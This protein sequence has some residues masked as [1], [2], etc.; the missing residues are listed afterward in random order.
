[1][2]QTTKSIR[3]TPER[4]EKLDAIDIPFS[5]LVDWALDNYSED[6]EKLLV[7][8]KHTRRHLRSPENQALSNI[9]AG[10]LLEDLLK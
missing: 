3:V 6:T 1:M 5:Q 4:A 7:L 10:A 2:E 9:Y 8:G